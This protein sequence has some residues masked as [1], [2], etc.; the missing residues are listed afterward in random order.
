MTEINKDLVK[1]DYLQGMKYKE[2]ATKFNVSIDTVKSWVKRYGW[3]KD[4][5]KVNKKGA[6]KEIKKQEKGC[7]QNKKVSDPKKGCT[8]K[9]RRSK[10]NIDMN[11]D[12]EPIPYIE[13]KDLNDK[14]KLFCIYYI[15]CFNATK[16]YQ[17]AYKCSYESAVTAGPR[18]LGNVQIKAEIMRLKADKLKGAY[19]SINDL[20]QK[21]IDVAL[22]D[23]NDYMSFG[24]K[25]I[26]KVNEDTGEEDTFKYNYVDFK[27]SSEVDGT[28]ISEVKQGKDGVSIKLIDK[29]WA[30]DFLAKYSGLLDMP[31]KQKLDIERRKMELAEKQADDL[32]EDIIYVD[33]DDENEE[34]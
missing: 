26:T 10:N 6:H 11:K 16:A 8:Q 14:Q 32:D 25:E 23:I 30:L 1:I 21:Y 27:E 29:K 15:K 2:I 12:Y 33:V 31:T 34:N 18:L 17:K 3:A 20:L 28:L 13:N 4:K 5:E 19:L 9:T 24:Q 7:T 22:S